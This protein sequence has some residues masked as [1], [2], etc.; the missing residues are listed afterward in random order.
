MTSLSKTIPAAL[1]MILAMGGLSAE[2]SAQTLLYATFS[3]TRFSNVP[4]SEIPGHYTPAPLGGSSYFYYGFGGGL[5]FSAHAARSLS[6][7]ID[8][9]A[10]SRPGRPGA[11]L[12]QAGLKLAPRTTAHG[13]SLYLEPAFG[14][15]ET[16][17]IVPLAGNTALP[18]DT[19]HYG[20]VAYQ[21]LGGIDVPLR[22][23]VGLRLLEVGG[24]QGF[25]VSGPNPGNNI[26]NVIAILTINTGLVFRF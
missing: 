24:G 3:P 26:P 16:R 14:W 8:L 13:A 23:S 5:T 18:G 20:F 21:V 25:R 11:D 6:T 17:T 10:F 19:N 12:F 2:S 7:A 9:R 22:S 1:A 15:A 4:N